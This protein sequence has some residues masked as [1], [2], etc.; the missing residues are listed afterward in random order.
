MGYFIQFIIRVW[1]KFELQG[2]GTLQYSRE[3]FDRT[4]IVTCRVVS[5]KRTLVFS[6]VFWK[7]S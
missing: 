7:R 4:Y 2:V 1:C 3:E 6:R 5:R